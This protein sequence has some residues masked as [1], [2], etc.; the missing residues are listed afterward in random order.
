MAP[1]STGSTFPAGVFFHQQ[2]Q[3]TSMMRDA[4]FCLFINTVFLLCRSTGSTFP[5]GVFSTSSG[6]NF[7]DA[8]RA[9]LFVHKYGFSLMPFRVTILRKFLVWPHQPWNATHRE[10]NRRQRNVLTLDRA[11][12]EVHGLHGP[13]AGSWATRSARNK[14]LQSLGKIMQSPGRMVSI[15]LVK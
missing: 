7:D 11:R 10:K 4:Q 9:I 6:K 3:K 1:R 12:V 8:R 15:S 2:W 14:L 13:A 5:A